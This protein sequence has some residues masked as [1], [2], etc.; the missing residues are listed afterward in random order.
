[1]MVMGIAMRDV[2]E[3]VWVVVVV[4]DDLGYGSSGEQVP[5]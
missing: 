3:V 5:P 4:C 1:M 2:S